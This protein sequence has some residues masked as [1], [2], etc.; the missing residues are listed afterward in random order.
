ML[1]VAERLEIEKKEIQTQDFHSNF[2]SFFSRLLSS[3]STSISGY[4][5]AAGTTGVDLTVCP[6]DSLQLNVALGFLQLH[7]WHLS[8]PGWEQGLLSPAAGQAV[9]S[10]TSSSA[11]LSWHPLGLVPSAR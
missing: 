10:P 5:Q 8:L 3:D 4:H 7:I 2:S 11:D 9:P 1:F 6:N